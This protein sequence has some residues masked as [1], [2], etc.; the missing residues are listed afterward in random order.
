[1]KYDQIISANHCGGTVR[2][3]KDLLIHENNRN[4]SGNINAVSSH[5]AI[6]DYFTTTSQ[7]TTFN[8]LNSVV[9]QPRAYYVTYDPQRAA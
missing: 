5:H 3:G 2:G 6:A 7:H 1:M 9:K 4:Q 8:S